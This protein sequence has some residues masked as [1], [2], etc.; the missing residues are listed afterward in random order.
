MSDTFKSHEGD[1]D[2]S[3][4]ISPRKISSSASRDI[5]R[6]A[7]FVI[8]PLGMLLKLISKKRGIF[9]LM[10]HFTKKERQ[11]EREK[12]RREKKRKEKKRKQNKTKQ[13]KT[14]Q[15]KTKCGWFV[16]YTELQF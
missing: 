1:S 7:L 14:K 16:S 10:Q 9:K 8:L 3:A 2:M 11:R 5:Y 13:N 6:Q 4:R 12:K 15:N